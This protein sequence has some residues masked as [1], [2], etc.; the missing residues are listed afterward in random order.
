M[1]Y[2]TRLSTDAPPA[3]ALLSPTGRRLEVCGIERLLKRTV[4][5]TR[6]ADPAR[7]EAMAPHGLRH[8]AA[9]MSRR[10]PRPTR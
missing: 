6:A 9:T 3:T 4:K 10:A 7:A 8:T 2:R 5:R 1:A